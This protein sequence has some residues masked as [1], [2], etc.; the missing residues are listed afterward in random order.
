MLNHYKQECILINLNLERWVDA[1]KLFQ[2]LENLNEDEKKQIEQLKIKILINCISDYLNI[3][4]FD[5]SENYLKQLYD[6][7][8]S[9]AYNLEIKLIKKKLAKHSKI[10]NMKQ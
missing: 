10:M 3:E 8:P 6:L 4:N 7:S 1:Y 5:K 2:S 9:D